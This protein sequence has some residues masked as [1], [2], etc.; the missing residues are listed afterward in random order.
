MRT[1]LYRMSEALN[2]KMFLGI[3]A[4]IFLAPGLA[5]EK[6]P[7][8]VPDRDVPAAIQKESPEVPAE[9][10]IVTQEPPSSKAVASR[11]SYYQVTSEVL[12]ADDPSMREIADMMFSGPTHRTEHVIPAPERRAAPR[13]SEPPRFEREERRVHAPIHV[14][15]EH[16]RPGSVVIVPVPIRPRH[17]HR[18]VH[19]MVPPPR[20]RVRFQDIDACHYFP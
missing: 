5:H 14:R 12:A 6:V 2:A 4:F 17:M 19:R 10:E 8:P 20:R 18:H 15:R 3:L 9:R 7:N 1:F 13:A 11:G 16:E